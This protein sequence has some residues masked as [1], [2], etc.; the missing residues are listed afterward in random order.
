[1]SWG[2]GAS[3]AG[4][5]VSIGGF[6][7][8]IREARKARTAATAAKD[9]V[10]KLRDVTFRT[11]TYGDCSRAGAVLEEVGRLQRRASWTDVP[12]R[13]AELRRLV[14]AIKTYDLHLTPAERTTL[15]GALSQFALLQATV[16]RIISG[17]EVN[18]NRARLNETLA[19]QAD[20]VQVVLVSVLNKLKA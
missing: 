1:M 10:E 14:V 17:D 16:E 8:T 3:V 11:L 7:V 20:R 2:D 6:I 12:D 4:L 15:Q 13:Y 5:V 18:P 9:A 19:E